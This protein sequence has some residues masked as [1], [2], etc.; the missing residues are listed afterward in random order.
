MDAGVVDDLVVI[1]RLDLPFSLYFSLLARELE[2]G[3]GFASDCVVSQPVW[4]LRS[5]TRKSG[6]CPAFRAIRRR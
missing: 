3:D 2:V 1:F 4:S 5:I 6:K